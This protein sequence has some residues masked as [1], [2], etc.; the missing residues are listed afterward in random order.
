MF[1]AYITLQPA[2][3]A[4]GKDLFTGATPTNILWEDET[5]TED[6]NDEEECPDTIDVKK[7]L[8]FETTTTLGFNLLDEG[9][10]LPPPPALLS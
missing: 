8:D 2:H 6:Y 5:A 10:E 4:S 9:I 1:H 3:D 7:A